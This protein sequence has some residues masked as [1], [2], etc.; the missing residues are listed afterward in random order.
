MRAALSPPS[1]LD[2]RES[3]SVIAPHAAKDSVRV[4]AEADWGPF[5]PWRQGGAEHVTGATV[6]YLK[7]LGDNA[8]D[9]GRTR[10]ALEL[11]AIRARLEAKG[12]YTDAVAARGRSSIAFGSVLPSVRVG[13]AAGRVDADRGSRAASGD[14]RRGARSEEPRLGAAVGAQ[15]C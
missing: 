14:W 8:S 11:A 5:K 9:W 1:G 2:P 10:C 7:S 4:A 13:S 15:R 3:W 6:R 12:V